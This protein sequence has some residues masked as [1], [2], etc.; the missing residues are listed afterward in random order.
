LDFNRRVLIFFALLLFTS[1]S[2][3][4]DY[5][6][7]LTT[8]IKSVK[9]SYSKKDYITTVKEANNV[10][11]HGSRREMAYRYLG[12]S[13]EKLEENI[14][15]I[16]A[17]TKYLAYCKLEECR[18]LEKKIE[19]LK[20]K[21]DEEELKEITDSIPDKVLFKETHYKE[22]KIFRV[23]DYIYNSLGQVVAEK[24]FKPNFSY[25]YRIEY[26][27]DK[28]SNLRLKVKFDEKNKIIE[29]E[30]FMYE[31]GKKVQKVKR[32]AKG[33]VV[34]KEV[35]KYNLNGSI[36]RITRYDKKDEPLTKK[37][38]LYNKGNLFKETFS[39]DQGSSSLDNYNAKYEYKD[40]KLK[41]KI[42]SYE[43]GLFEKVKYIYKRDRLTREVLYV[44]DKA[45]KTIKYTYYTSG[46]LYEAG[47]YKILNKSKYKLESKVNYSYYNL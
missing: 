18:E 16:L 5:A 44:D 33:N 28:E 17:Y 22:E 45:V 43:R 29:T 46:E 27:Y 4:C 9:R 10:L 24:Y 32:G 21:V 20:A 14:P 37:S 39:G 1:K 13:Y 11:Y 6:T 15:A 8:H 19:R 36:K 31:E 23:R 7:P 38:F 35:Y 3:F 41:E 25:E 26:S 12:R 42:I 47:Q 2:G 30:T 34:D 40:G